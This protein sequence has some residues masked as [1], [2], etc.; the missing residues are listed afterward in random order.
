[1]AYHSWKR[2]PAQCER[3]A[4]LCVRGGTEGF[5]SHHDTIRLGIPRYHQQTSK[6]KIEYSVNEKKWHEY[7]EEGGAESPMDVAIEE[8][9]GLVDI[10]IDVVGGVTEVT[11]KVHV[12]LVNPIEE[13]II[14]EWN[15][16]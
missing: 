12:V 16:G 2:R 9:W 7:G 11:G 3:V 13:L 15:K 14:L 4:K 8:L 10:D 1:M 6:D 5:A